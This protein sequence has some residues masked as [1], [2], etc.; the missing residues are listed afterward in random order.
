MGSCFVFVFMVL[1]FSAVHWKTYYDWQAISI[2]EKSVI[3]NLTK[4][5]KIGRY[6]LIKVHDKFILNYSYE[7]WGRWPFAFKL[8]TGD[9][10]RYAFGSY[11]YGNAYPYP[12]RE[13]VNELVNANVADPPWRSETDKRQIL[14]GKQAIM[15]IEPGVF[16][17]EFV[18]LAKGHDLQPTLEFNI[19]KR[20]K[21]V[22][23][24]KYL[25]YRSVDREKLS[26]FLESITNVEVRGVDDLFFKNQSS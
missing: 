6:Q 18:E 24:A 12:N 8:V 14:E 11:K 4:Q 20:Q 13:L 22:L 5:K 10:N 21:L 2:K 16:F 9:Y 25:Y 1:S 23:V 3:H 7:Q 17:Q 19:G 26:R 15:T